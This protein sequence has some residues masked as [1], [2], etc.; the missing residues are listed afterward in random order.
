MNKVCCYHRR[1]EEAEPSEPGPPPERARG[2]LAGYLVLAAAIVGALGVG[3][4]LFISSGNDNPASTPNLSGLTNPYPNTGPLEPNRPK[5]DESAPD[6]ALVDA[7]DPSKVVKLSDFRG[8]AVVVNW[9]ASWCDPC[10]REIPA[11]QAAYEKL[12]GQLVVLGVD[13]LES[14]KAALSILDERNADYPAV[15]DA[16]GSVA[17]H[18]RVGA[19]LPVS[20]FIDKD[21]VLRR[22]KTGEVKKDALSGYLREV[23]IEYSP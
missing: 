14:Q 5:E 2:G 11:L 19:G 22:I 8:K 6:F 4:Y 18:Y 3:A 9:Y 20:F 10:Q 1:V 23:G 7:R 13:Y 17:E 12:G 15:L 21:G 16:S